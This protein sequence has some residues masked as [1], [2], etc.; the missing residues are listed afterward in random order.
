[1]PDR[2]ANAARH[3]TE[4]HGVPPLDENVDFTPGAREH[5]DLVGVRSQTVEAGPRSVARRAAA[6][7]RRA[8]A[9]RS[10]RLT[11]ARVSGRER[12][13]RTRCALARRR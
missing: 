10:A 6:R 2:V 4:H 12:R 11:P 9:R 8:R 1:M 5:G 7:V 3:A 13:R